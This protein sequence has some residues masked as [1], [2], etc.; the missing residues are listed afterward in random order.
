MA[1]LSP[2]GGV[3]DLSPPGGVADLSPPGGAG[4]VAAGAAAAAA[5]GVAAS[6]GTA[7]RTSDT[8]LTTSR[9]A[10]ATMVS[11]SRRGTGREI[12]LMSACR[13]QRPQQVAF[14]LAAQTRGVVGLVGGQAIPR[15][16]IPRLA[17]PRQVIP[18][19]VI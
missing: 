7:A 5:A 17:I 16:V 4:G 11:G 18:R 6:A 10:I 9:A 13:A 15:Q 8:D 14:G 1:D 3:A 2:P 12:L 19:Q